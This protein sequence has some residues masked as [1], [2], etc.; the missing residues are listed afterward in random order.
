MLSTRSSVPCCSHATTC[1]PAFPKTSRIS[2]QHDNRRCSRV[3]TKAYVEPTATFAITQQ[4]IAYA[5]VLGGDL[6]VERRSKMPPQIPV[7]LAGVAGTLAAVAILNSGQ[8][9][10]VG[11][12]MITGLI[13]AGALLAY[14]A[15]RTAEIVDEDA[16][17][18]GPKAVPGIIA[19]IS[20][21]ELCVF[22]QGIKS[23]L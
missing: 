11:V 15:K 6:Y 20:F 19:L 22:I 4:A 8:E 7:A 1:L 16:D 21:F 13:T 17:W 9:S 14:H 18:P 2:L 12:G 5:V 10:L 3:Q 23:E